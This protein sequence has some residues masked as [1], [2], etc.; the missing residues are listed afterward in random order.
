MVRFMFWFM[1]LGAVL[2]PARTG[3]AQNEPA[4]PAA[5][6]HVVA[7]PEAPHGPDR[8]LVRLLDRYVWIMPAPGHRASVG[9]AAL[10][11]LVLVLQAA[12][13][14]A[15]IE[16]RSFGRCSALAAIL[17]GIT[18]IEVSLAPLTLGFVVAALLLNTGIWF[19][20]TRWLLRATTVG[21]LVMA[22]CFV[23]AVLLGVLLIEVMRFV[24]SGQML[25]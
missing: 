5:E 11:V 24:L 16:Q 12:A 3:T 17:F 2:L 6:V 21:S 18:A 10:V 22:V 9:A 25:A 7:Q 23:F 14:M 15:E 20:A 4:A 19:G 13:R 1:L 8:H